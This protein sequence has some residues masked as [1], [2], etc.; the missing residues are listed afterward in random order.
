MNLNKALIISLCILVFLALITVL[1]LHCTKKHLKKYQFE[2][3]HAN[4]EML[5]THVNCAPEIIRSYEKVKNVYGEKNKLIFR[6]VNNSCGSCIN[7]YL[8][9]ILSLQEEIGKDYIWIF[10]AYPDDRSSRIQ[11]SSE[12][13]KYNYRN[14]PADSL[15][16]PIF[17]DEPKSYFAWLNNE[18]EIEMIFMPDINKPHYTRNFFLEVRRKIKMIDES[19]NKFNYKLR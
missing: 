8:I 10:P 15:H 5:S 19:P 12:L 6:Y 18:G 17:I 11:L 1:L 3:A 16:I 9:E 2:Y 14:I 7:R 4:Y 13:A